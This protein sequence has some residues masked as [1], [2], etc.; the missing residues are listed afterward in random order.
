MKALRILLILLAVFFL[1]SFPLNRAINSSRAQAG[2]PAPSA[3]AA[4]AAVQPQTAPSDPPGTID[5]SK[6]P[7]LIPDIVAYR[8][9]LLGIAEPENATDAQQAR[10]RAKI[11]SA[12]LNEDDLQMLLGILGTFQNQM[13][14]L[15]AQANQILARDPIPFAGT[16]DYQSLVGLSKQREPVFNQAMSALSA[17]LSA[18]GAAKLQ[19]YV[20]SAKRG[21]KYL[22]ESPMPQQ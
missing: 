5:G 12:Q 6:N 20:E 22:P 3:A 16:P 4:P 18:D 1:A 9:V 17:R 15:T 13:D 11:A 10:F 7:E 8:L 14:A 2:L 19:A 21:M